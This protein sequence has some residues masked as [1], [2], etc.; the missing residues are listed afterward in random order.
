MKRFLFGMLLVAIFVGAAYLVQPA[1]AALSEDI[2]PNSDIKVAGQPGVYYYARDGV[3]HAYPDMATFLSYHPGGEYNIVNV[4]QVFL[5][6]LPSGETSRVS[7]GTLVKFGKNSG[8][9]LS[10]VY[11]SLCY[12]TSTAAADRDFGPGWR[13]RVV[14]TMVDISNY[15]IVGPCFKA[16][17]FNNTYVRYKGMN[18]VTSTIFAV[19]SIFHEDGYF[20]TL[21]DIKDDKSIELSYQ[22]LFLGQR[23]SQPSLDYETVSIPFGTS[24]CVSSNTCNSGDL[25]CFST[26]LSGGALELTWRLEDWKQNLGASYIDMGGKKL[27]ENETFITGSTFR[28]ENY[29][30]TL[31][32][33]KADNSIDLTYSNDLLGMPCRPPQGGRETVNIPQATPICITS[34]TCD[35]GDSVCF[36]AGLKDGI[37]NLSWE[38]KEWN[39]MPKPF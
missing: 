9:Y 21:G 28:S 36:T 30:F 15:K 23:C 39:S 6:S 8:I 22:K 38:V 17:A 35:G 34:N 4:S 14:N 13:D 24:T 25:A 37:I 7:V 12:A 2:S 10:E 19:N 1:G 33:V 26:A 29:Y 20:F 32:D 11:G 5:D 31:E 27:Y 16:L 3:K 18:L